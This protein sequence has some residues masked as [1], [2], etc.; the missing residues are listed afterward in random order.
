MYVSPL[1]PF[2]LTLILGIVWQAI[3][4]LPWL[5]F[6]L[7]IILCSTFFTKTNNNRL[8][9][10]AATSCCFFFVGALRYQQ[11]KNYFE[12][13]LSQVINKTCTMKAYI[14]DIE[15]SYK[16]PEK[17]VITVTIEE[18]KNFKKIIACAQGMQLK[19]TTKEPTGKLQTGDLVMCPRRCSLIR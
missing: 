17:T 10:I 15:P 6:P 8:L 13:C 7:V 9:I 16:H 11:Q 3:G 5:A 18:L 12:T 2:S 19:I 14:A 4:F 1:L